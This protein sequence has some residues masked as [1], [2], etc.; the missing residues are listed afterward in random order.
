PGW[1]STGAVTAVLLAEMGYTGDTTVLDNPERGFAYIAGYPNWFPDELTEELGTTWIYNQKLHYKPYPCCGAFH[2][3]LDCF[4]KIIEEHDL[5]PEEI[6]SVKVLGAG[7]MSKEMS[8]IS[9]AQFNMQYNMAVAA[10]RITRGV[11]WVDPETMSNPNI[12]GFMEK[13]SGQPHPDAGKEMERDPR[14][15]LG[16][17][18][19]TARGKTFSHQIQYRQGDTFT[20]GAWTEKEIVDKFRHNAAR[21]LTKQKTEKAVETILNLEKTANISELMGHVTL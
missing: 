21:I 4:C 2:S 15:R 6:E 9:S 17:A 8:S 16:K 11:E 1:Q 5:V 19:V 13:V 10:H 12:L 14:T 20:D 7:S 18:D 3:V